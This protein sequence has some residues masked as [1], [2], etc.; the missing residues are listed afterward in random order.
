MPKTAGSTTYGKLELK[1]L[2]HYVEKH[3]PFGMSHCDKVA[4]GYNDRASKANKPTRTS[5]SLKKKFANLCNSKKTTDG[6]DQK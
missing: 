4:A 1:W 2:F 6:A 5:V 3:R